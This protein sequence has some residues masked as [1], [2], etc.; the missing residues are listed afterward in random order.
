MPLTAVNREELRGIKSKKED[1]TLPTIHNKSVFI[2]AAINTSEDREGIVLDIPRT[3]LHAWTK[4]E[5]I[6]L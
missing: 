2:K 3:F 6:M 4:D 1:A 5:A